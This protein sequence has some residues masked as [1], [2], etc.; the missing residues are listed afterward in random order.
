M[1]VKRDGPICGI[2]TFSISFLEKK[3]PF[4]RFS[5]SSTLFMVNRA[6]IIR[7]DEDG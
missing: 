1:K 3:T 4:C 6:A 5:S 2:E 7:R